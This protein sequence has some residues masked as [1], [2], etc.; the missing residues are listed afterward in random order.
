MANA[1]Y[2]IGQRSAPQA[3]RETIRSQQE[4]ADAFERCREHLRANGVDLAATQAVAGP[5]VTLDATRECF[6]GDF[7][8]QANA[9]SQRVY[10]KPFV[11]S[12][13]T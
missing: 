7:A 6:V 1:S 12:E 13:V 8:D 4:L 5:W 10:R 2:R 9:V 3:I 11:V